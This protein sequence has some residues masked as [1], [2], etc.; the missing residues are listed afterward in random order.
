MNISK[1]SK[2]LIEGLK[3]AIG[4]NKGIEEAY[5]ALVRRIGYLEK[6]IRFLKMK[7]DG[8]TDLS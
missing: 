5:A 3:A 4:N 8:K 1:N 6:R 2:E 7:D